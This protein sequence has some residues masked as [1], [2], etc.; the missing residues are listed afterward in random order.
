MLKRSSMLRAALFNLT[1]IL[2]V[3]AA[4]VLGWWLSV[5]S[6]AHRSG[7]GHGHGHHV[8][9]HHNHQKDGADDVEALKFNILGQVFG[10][11]CALLYLGSRIPQLLL[12]YRR[13]ST[14]GVSM[15]FFMFA[16]LGN[17]T[18]V[19]SILLYDPPCSRSDAGGGS[20]RA[21]G[22]EGACV[23][24]EAR[25]MYGRYFLVNLSWFIGSF[26]TLMLDAGVFVQYFLYRDGVVEGDG[27][28]AVDDA[29]R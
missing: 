18:Y 6:P 13:K 25:R 23:P 5:A 28:V 11:I 21:S 27:E 3:C 24:G 7:D 15:L 2:V 22:V 16:C 19:L 10:Y 8:Q 14:E 20:S 12:N 1:A 9:H 4:G 26:G 29:V 17:L